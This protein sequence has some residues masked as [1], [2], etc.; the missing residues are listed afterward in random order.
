M[1]GEL[2]PFFQVLGFLEC[3]KRKSPIRRVPGDR[4]AYSG[5]QMRTSP[6]QPPD[7][8]RGKTQSPEISRKFPRLPG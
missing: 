5:F 4:A 7:S 6:I 2:E 8:A 1:C 3:L